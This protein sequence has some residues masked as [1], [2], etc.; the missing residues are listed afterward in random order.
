LARIGGGALLLFAIALA[1]TRPN[2]S[3]L[4]VLGLLLTWGLIADGLFAV[5]ARNATKKMKALSILFVVVVSPTGTVVTSLA[6]PLH[7][8]A[9]AR[10]GA[11]E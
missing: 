9:V 8:P 2:P 11:R 6:F 3:G 10:S 5:I 4:L 1:L 7:R